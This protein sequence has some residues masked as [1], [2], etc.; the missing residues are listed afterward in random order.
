MIMAERHNTV[1]CTYDLASPRI[2]AYDI[3]EW[4][5]ASLRIPENDVQLIQIDGVSRQEFIKLTDS[6]KVFA[7]LRD[8]GD[9][10]EYIYPTGEISVASLALVVM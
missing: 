3:N 10:V 9:E 7:V 4:I 6:D 2:T 8:K 1:V 5:Y